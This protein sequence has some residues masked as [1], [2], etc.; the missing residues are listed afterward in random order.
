MKR[1][2]EAQKTRQ[3]LPDV[4][5]QWSHRDLLDCPSYDV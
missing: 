4:V 1:G 5:F 2:G 3:K